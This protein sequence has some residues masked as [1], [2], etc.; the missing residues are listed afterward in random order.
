[1]KAP[2]LVILSLLLV[3]AILAPAVLRLVENGENTAIAID[4]NEEEKK[5]EKKEVSEKDFFLNSDLKPPIV[6]PAEITSIANF[7]LE[8][9]YSTALVIFLPPPKLAV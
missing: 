3:T 9:E 8:S 7:Y 2:I 1:M 5:E 4:F 6:V